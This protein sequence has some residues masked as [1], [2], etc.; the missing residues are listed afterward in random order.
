M[1]VVPA[2][3]IVELLPG[4][5]FAVD[6]ATSLVTNDDS[7]EG[8][9]DWLSAEVA[10]FAGISLSRETGEAAG[11]ELSVDDAVAVGSPTSGVRADELPLDRE[12][13]TLTVSAEGIRVAGASAEGVFRGATTLLHLVT[14]A[15]DA[16]Q[17]VLQGV[18]IDDAPT[19]AWR[20]LSFDVVRTFHPVETVRKVID[21]LALYKMNV[22]HL[23]LTDSEG[24]RFDVPAYPELTGISGMT[25]RG[26]RP[27]GFYTREEYAGIL[28]YAAERFI[29]VVPEFD[30]PGHTA[31]VLRA[32]P[33]LG[34]PEILG[35]PEPMQYLHPDLPGVWDLV[36]AVY[37]E[38]ARVHPG[39]R[40]HIGGDEAIA[41]DEETFSRY[42]AMALPAARG[43]GKG[44]VAWQETARAGFAD[45]DLMQWWIPPHLIERVQEAA[46]N[47]DASWVTSSFPDPAVREAFMR[48]FLQAPE[49][50]PKAIAQG[51]SVIV[52]RADK[53]YLDTK[54][55][56]PS[57]DP[58]QE[59]DRQRVG[60]PQ[61]VYGQGT[62]EDSYHWSPEALDPALPADRL[63]GIEA[64]IWC[65]TIED[66]RDL[67]FQLLPRLPGVAEKA[68][69]DPRDWADYMPR[70]AAQRRCW[71][72][73][74]VS[75]FL[76]SVVWQER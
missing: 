60:I 9:A 35:S 59:A 19:L 14:H 50:L 53:L 71:D 6:G 63:A 20:G 40:I 37:E 48:L 75:Y 62:V 11:I 47:P 1:N 29:T 57:S 26:G 76:S 68:W 56:E 23:H 10:R 54:Y 41:M 42:M 44:I 46:A 2:P 27:G 38:M 49:D 70:L 39:G 43:T 74:G 66:E 34:T 8:V 12:R 67:M 15:A 22:L 3:R 18:M 58:G 5:S 21:L 24:W 64:A 25:A 45:G 73:M 65:E 32:Y 4:Q 28:D 17:A 13:Y 30:S 72:A 61:S 33:E 51:A 31:S 36:G 7:L 52:S 69:S 55:V 16:G